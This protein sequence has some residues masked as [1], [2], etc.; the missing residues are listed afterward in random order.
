MRRGEVQAIEA[1]T[2][3]YPG[4]T[5]SL[6]A[7]LSGLSRTA[8]DHRLAE[9]IEWGDVR[10]EGRDGAGDPYGFYPVATLARTLRGETGIT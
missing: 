7:R 2:R 10:E 5:A 9:L 3:W 1:L 4:A 8:V 6:L